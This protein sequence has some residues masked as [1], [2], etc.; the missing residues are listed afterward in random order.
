[1]LHD[2][3]MRSGPQW[4]GRSDVGVSKGPSEPTRSSAFPV[5]CRCECAD[6]TAELLRHSGVWGPDGGPGE[7]PRPA[8]P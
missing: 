2:V 7:G 5:A 8:G 1:M 6:V 3:A 4:G